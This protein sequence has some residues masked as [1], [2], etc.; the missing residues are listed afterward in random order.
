MRQHQ[1]VHVS[2]V[3]GRPVTTLK[4]LGGRRRLA[5]LAAML[6]AEYPAWGLHVARMA[7]EDVLSHGDR[8]Q[9]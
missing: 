4:G 9:I 6:F 3:P 8:W 5:R 2:G 7:L 1:R